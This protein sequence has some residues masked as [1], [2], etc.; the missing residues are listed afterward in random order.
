MVG[1]KVHSFHP[2][3]PGLVHSNVVWVPPSCRERFNK[4]S[5]GAMPKQMQALSCSLLWLIGSRVVTVV[6][7]ESAPPMLN[8]RFIHFT[9]HYLN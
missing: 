5:S 4:C 2:A 9:L 6:I 1:V 3:L 7:R 8:S